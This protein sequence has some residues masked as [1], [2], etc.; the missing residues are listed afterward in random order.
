MHQRGLERA[1]LPWGAGHGT[2]PRVMRLAPMPFGK[3]LRIRRERLRL[4]QREF[5][6]A[7]GLTQQIVSRLEHGETLVTPALL[8]RIETAFS[9]NGPSAT[10]LYMM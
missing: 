10:N 1:S 2:R 4:T 3:T 8:R 5:A 7:S 9:S 6:R